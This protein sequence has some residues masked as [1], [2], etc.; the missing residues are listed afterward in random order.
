M[1]FDADP[2]PNIL[3]PVDERFNLINGE[4]YALRRPPYTKFMKT[5]VRFDIDTM[6][7]LESF[8]Y[9]WLHV[10]NTIE[11]SPDNEPW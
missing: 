9:H 11:S 10:D 4:N 3:H 7:T 5:A 2:E 6:I 1:R 8:R